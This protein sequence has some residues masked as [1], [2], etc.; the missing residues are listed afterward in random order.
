MVSPS[1][2]TITTVAPTSSSPAGGLTPSITTWAVGRFE[3][4]TAT[5]GLAGDRDWPTSAAWA[6]LDNDGD[7]DLYVCHYLK[8]DEVKPTLCPA[9]G[10]K[11]AHL[12]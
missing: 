12:L 11:R 8:W 2:T 9:P 6:D 1:A 3:D 10:K 7:L 5:A 4:A